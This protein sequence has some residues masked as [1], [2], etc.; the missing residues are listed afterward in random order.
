[1][2][3]PKNIVRVRD[4][5]EGQGPDYPAKSTIYK[6][7]SQRKFPR[8]VYTVPGVGLVFDLNEWQAMCEAAQQASE[9]RAHKIH[10]AMV[11]SK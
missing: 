7:H 3:K 10:K 8:L 4:I 11:V 1:M 9:E 6:F 2:A 5:P